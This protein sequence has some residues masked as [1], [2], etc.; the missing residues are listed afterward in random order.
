MRQGMM[1]EPSSHRSDDELPPSDLPTCMRLIDHAR[2]AGDM[3]MLAEQSRWL[4]KM[5]PGHPIARTIQAEVFRYDRQL[6]AARDILADVLRLMPDFLPAV[7]EAA[8]VEDALGNPAAAFTLRLKAINLAEAQRSRGFPSGIANALERAVGVV[9]AAMAETLDAVLAVHENAHGPEALLRIR[10]AVDIFVGRRSRGDEHP[11]WS[12]GL[13]YVPGLEPLPWFE[14][15]AFEWA[16]R[17]EQATPVIR[18]E[19][20]AAMGGSSG[21]LPYVDD[22]GGRKRSDYW[23]ELNRSRRWSAFHFSRHGRAVEENRQRCPATAAVL[24]SLPLMRIPGY[25]PEAM[26]SVLEPRTKIPPHYGSVNGRLT[27]HL[28]LVVPRD[29]GALRVRGESRAWEEGKLLVFDDAMIHEAWNESD[30]VRAVLI[31]DVWNPQLTP[32]ERAAFSDVL[33]A[34]QRLEAGVHAP[35]SR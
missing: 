18:A 4:A 12:P 21:F 27:V 11:E 20:L 13:M 15:T 9:N 19:L 29:C 6:P 10:G 24:D 31:F 32:V 28:P 23:A 25:A 17:I 8:E 2:N 7:L 16:D 3:Q 1:H 14:K 22:S 5:A 33:T 26:F 34:A 35:T 30:Q